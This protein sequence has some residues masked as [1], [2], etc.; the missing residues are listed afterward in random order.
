MAEGRC[1]IKQP[2]HKRLAATVIA[3][4]HYSPR[5]A[6]TVGYFIHLPSSR[7]LY[8]LLFVERRYDLSALVSPRIQSKLATDFRGVPIT[9]AITRLQSQ[10]PSLALKVDQSEIMSASNMPSL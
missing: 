3:A 6:P 10:H 4:N 5:T 1:Q 9:L 2:N 7:K 8:I